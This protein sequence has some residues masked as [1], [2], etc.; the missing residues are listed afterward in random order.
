[1]PSNRS[2]FVFLGAMIVAAT[3]VRLIPYVLQALGTPTLS[4]FG[5][6]DLKLYPWNFSPIMAICLFGGVQFA[7]RKWAYIVPLSAII[8][9]NIGIGAIT[10]EWRYT[11]YSTMPITLA[12]FSLTVWLGTW[13]QGHRAE[14]P[15]PYV[16]Q[17][18]VAG[19]ASEIIFFLVTN[20]SEWAFGGGERY[21]LTLQGLGDCYIAA[22][23]FFR[24]SVT[25]V[26]VYS[27]VLFGGLA[28]AERRIPAIRMPAYVRVK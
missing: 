12:C 1:M 22:I 8:L 11:F 6:P 13:L 14:H 25:S 10:D 18:A 3:A 26:W 17:I 20:F 4:S 23:P 15:L 7:D 9:S 27:T 28:L 24:N 2:R 5:A 19:L 16:G 21:A